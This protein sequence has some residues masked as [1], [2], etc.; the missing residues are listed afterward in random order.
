MVERYR[1][2]VVPRAREAYQ[3]YLTNFRQMAAAYPQALIAQRTLFQ[4]EVEYARAL[5]Q[6]RDTTVRLRGFLLD[7]GLDPLSRPGDGT[8]G[9]KLRAPSEATADPDNK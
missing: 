6:L 2:A 7:G 5:V 1:T 3:T 9:L 8:E 4:V